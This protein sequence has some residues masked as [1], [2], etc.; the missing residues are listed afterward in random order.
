MVNQRQKELYIYI[1]TGILDTKFSQQDLLKLKDYNEDCKE[2][3]ILN[4]YKKYFYSLKYSPHT[5]LYVNNIERYIWKVEFYN[6]IIFE[7][8]NRDL[9]ITTLKNINNNDINL[10]EKDGIY[11]PIDNF[12]EMLYETKCNVTYDDITFLNYNDLI[13]YFFKKKGISIDE[14]KKI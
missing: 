7:Y 4:L 9:V 14:V 13:N 2:G 10:F 3:E 12:K 11:L 5:L 8:N 6:K 1:I